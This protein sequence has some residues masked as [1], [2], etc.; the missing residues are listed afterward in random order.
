VRIDVSGTA[1]AALKNCA[2]NANDFFDVPN[3]PDLPGV[4]ANIAGEIG[5][6]RI[7]Q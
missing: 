3:V 7:S 1:P 5:Q 4:F 6:L 2:T